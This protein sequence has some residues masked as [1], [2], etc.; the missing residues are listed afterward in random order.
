ALQAFAGPPQ[1]PMPAH[2]GKRKP[3]SAPLT[4]LWIT[5]M[6][7]LAADTLKA[8]QTPLQALAQGHPALARWT[9]GARTGDTGSAE[10][11]AQSRQLPTVLVTTPESL[12]LLLARADA[13]ELLGSVRLV[14]ADEW[15]ELLGNKRGVQLQLALARLRGWS[16]QLCVWGMS[17]TLGNLDEAMQTLLGLDDH[18]QPRPGVLVQGQVDKRLVVDTLLP[19]RPE[20]FSWAGHLGLAMLPAVVRELE[21]TAGSTLVFVNVRSQAELWYKALLEARP[22]WAGLLA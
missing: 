10:R 4:V 13:R 22:D 5:P 21:A 9:V 16:P 6:R 1:T 20:R 7:A 2:T 3:A 8:L 11:S 14:V 18:G 15:H 12:S 17:A 19:D